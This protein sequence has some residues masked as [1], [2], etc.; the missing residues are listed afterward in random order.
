MY[1]KFLS[2]FEAENITKTVTYFVIAGLII[3]ISLVVGTSDNILMIAMLLAGIILFF[4]AAL[5]LWEKTTYYAILAAV[6]LV[7]L[8]LDFIWP[9]I[10][11]GVAMSVG[12]IC[13]AGIIA[14][15]IGMARFRRY[16]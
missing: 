5:R 8:I 15:F 4:H 14:G 11:E 13:F 12:L 7:I 6:C 16:E 3:A 9:F 1:N 10:S 2:R